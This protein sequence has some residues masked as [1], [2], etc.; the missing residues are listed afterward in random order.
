[1]NNNLTI[2]TGLWDIG[3]NGRPFDHYIQHLNKFLD[4]E[5][6]L[7]LYGVLSMTRKNIAGFFESN[8]NSIKWSS[9]D[10]KVL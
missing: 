10:F 1:M 6:N 8:I 7:F 2:V 9:T 4:I 3:R 5:A